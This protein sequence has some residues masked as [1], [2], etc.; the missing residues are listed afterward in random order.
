[1]IQFRYISPEI[2]QSNC[3]KTYVI[4]HNIYPYIHIPTNINE[5]YHLT[6]K[7][8]SIIIQSLKLWP[9]THQKW[10]HKIICLKCKFKVPSKIY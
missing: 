8:F 1:M 2:F 3:C 5:D 4:R 7:H 6:L 10:K 9:N